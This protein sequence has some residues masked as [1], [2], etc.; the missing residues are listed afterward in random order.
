MLTTKQIKQTLRAGKYAW[1]GGYPL[2]FI[3]ADGAALSFDAVKEN[4]YQVC[5]STRHNINDGWMIEGC[6]VNWE[7]NSLFCDHT[8]DPIECAYCD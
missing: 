7:D 4:W 3:T 8:G 6:D 5:Y 1:P 2:F